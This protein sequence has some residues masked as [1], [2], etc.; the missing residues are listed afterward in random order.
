M[1]HNAKSSE[2]YKQRLNSQTIIN[3]K[4]TKNVKRLGSIIIKA[5]D[6]TQAN[7][8]EPCA[9]NMIDILHKLEEAFD[10]K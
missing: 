3:E 4:L 1:A 10:G 2:L 9:Q 8:N 5:M 6:M 7:L